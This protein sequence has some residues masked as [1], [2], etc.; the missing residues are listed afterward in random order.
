MAIYVDVQ[1]AHAGTY[2]VPTEQQLGAW[3]QAAL[4]GHREEAEL[5]IRIVDSEES[6][7]LNFQYR[8][9]D[10]PTNV[11]SFPADIPDYIQTP[12]LGD[13]AICAE[14]VNIEAA[15]QHK[16]PEHH[17]AHMVMHGCLHLVGY[18][19]IEE[20]DAETMEALEINLLGALNIAN[21]YDLADV[22]PSPKI[23][24]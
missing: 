8:G 23:A 9:K 6:Q 20:Q 19:H 24:N 2:H 17:W 5:S 3:A 1:F 4:A 21:P 22:A 14:I 7:L 15:E 13:L 10:K 11:L 12:L 18:D 16:L